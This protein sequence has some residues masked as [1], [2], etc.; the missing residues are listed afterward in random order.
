[1]AIG[2]VFVEVSAV[3]IQGLS[4]VNTAV[5]GATGATG[6]NGATGPQ[7][8]SGSTGINGASGAQGNTGASGVQG[9][10]GTQGA[11]GIQGDT[12]ASGIDG[13]S[14]APALWNFTGAYGGGN[15]YAVGDVA[16][17]DGQ[18]WYRINSNG[19]NTGDTPSEGIFWTLIA[20]Q[21]ATGIQGASGIEG[22]TGY[23]GASGAGVAPTVTFTTSSTNQVVVETIDVSLYRSVK[24]EMQLTY[25]TSYQASE[26]RLLIDD[27]N[28]FL[29]EYG[30]IG[31][32]LGSFASYYSP[33]SNDYSGASINNGGVS[34]WTGTALRVYT[35][36]NTVQQ[37]LLSAPAGT[38]I[39]INSGAASATINT[40]FIE[41]DAGIYDAVTTTSRSPS[42]L[43]SRLQWT[44]SGNIELRFTPV[45]SVTALKYKRTYIEV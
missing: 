10:T 5:N 40:S 6:I 4:G 44:G 23:T 36:N 18:T 45:Y 8:A 2:D 41:T 14:G 35:T 3:G 21:G 29:T 34:V 42:L 11:S 28:V 39:N 33:A 32:A 17:Y 38:V 12:G 15:S 22:A 7:G 25:N 9:S 26:L 19:G 30:V 43:L 27:P 1:M 37:A 31:D 13:A 16:T 20:A 24:Y